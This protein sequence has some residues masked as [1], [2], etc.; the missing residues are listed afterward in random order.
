M[1][2]LSASGQRCMSVP[3]RSA[4]AL[5]VICPALCQQPRSAMVGESVMDDVHVVMQWAKEQKII[6]AASGDGARMVF[7]EAVA[8]ERFRQE[9]DYLGV[10]GNLF[11]LP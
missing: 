9:R 1:E 11:W 6:V 2:A 3:P 10:A 8:S 5:S 7:D 4:S